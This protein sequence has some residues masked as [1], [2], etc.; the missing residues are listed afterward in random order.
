VVLRVGL[1]ETAIL[2]TGDVEAASEASLRRDVGDRLPAAVLKAPHHGSRTSSTPAFVEAVGPLVVVI[3]VGAGN[4]YGLPAA[5]VEARYR[6][7]GACVLRTDHCGAI[8]VVADGRRV[9]VTTA[10]PGCGCP[11]GSP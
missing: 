2:L 4:R 8:T 11:A 3:P 5:E 10:R 1:G 7:R 6:A 9:A